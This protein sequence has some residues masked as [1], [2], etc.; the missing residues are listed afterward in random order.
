MSKL[1]DWCELFRLPNVFTA[2]ADPLAGALIA[3][4]TWGHAGSILVLMMASACLYTAGIVLNDWHDFKQDLAE[5]P[6][7]PLPSKRIGRLSAL[8]VTIGLFVLGGLLGTVPGTG[9][10]RV[11][12]LLIA[13]IL[14]YDVLLKEIPIAPVFMGGCRALNLL[15]GMTLV[16]AEHSPVGWSMRILLLAAM[17]LYVLGVTI[18][19][20][21]E[22]EAGQ[23]KYLVGGGGV[24]CVA[25]LV[26]GLLRFFFPDQAP[27]AEGVAWAAL[28]MLAI[29][30]RMTQALLTPKPQNVQLAVKTALW[31]VILLDAAMV[32]FTRGVPAS[33]AVVVLLVPAIWLGKR[34]SST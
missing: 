22:T 12:G 34:L 7:R 15:L 10:S 30:Y 21:R 18:F 11:T 28:L 9:P 2:M 24:A 14:L 13:T 26:V 23:G 5:R 29:G 3:G 16:P 32:A 17:G 6:Q 8:L 31:G 27:R 1:R 20:R 19:A 25:V 4:A 33:L